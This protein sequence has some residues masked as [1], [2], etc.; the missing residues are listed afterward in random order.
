MSDDRFWSRAKN[1]ETL[2]EKCL[3]A[4]MGCLLRRFFLS[5]KD[6]VSGTAVSGPCS[7][8]HSAVTA[9]MEFRSSNENVKKNVGIPSCLI[10]AI[11]SPQYFFQ[12]GAESMT[13]RN[14]GRML[15]AVDRF[16]DADSDRLGSS[17]D[18]QY[19][20]F[21]APGKCNSRPGHRIASQYCLRN[22]LSADIRRC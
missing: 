1:L 20:S 18:R 22:D 17:A 5:S 9:S 4:A 16:P 19:Q 21:A 7:A 14:L 2:I 6:S 13:C 8:T 11:K 15:Q 10:I 12:Y 3:A